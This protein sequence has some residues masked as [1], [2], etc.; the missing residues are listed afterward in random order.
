MLAVATVN[1]IIREKDARIKKLEDKLNE[2]KQFKSTTEKLNA[3]FKEKNKEV[4]IIF[5]MKYS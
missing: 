3:M 2:L 1:M 5:N 4:N